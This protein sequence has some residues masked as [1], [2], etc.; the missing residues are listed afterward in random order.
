[1][2]REITCM[3]LVAVRKEDTVE[4]QTML[5]V[6]ATVLDGRK[7]G[8]KDSFVYNSVYNAAIDNTTVQSKALV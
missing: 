5:K 1:M 7:K 6:A 2:R 3:I 4:V 8:P